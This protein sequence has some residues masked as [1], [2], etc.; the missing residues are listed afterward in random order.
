MFEFFL[1]EQIIDCCLES[2]DTLIARDQ[3]GESSAAHHIHELRFAHGATLVWNV[4]GHG[5]LLGSF[6]ERN[7]AFPN[8]WV[9]DNRSLELSI[10]AHLHLS[11]MSQ[12]QAV[13]A[14]HE[15]DLDVVPRGQSPAAFDDSATRALVNKKD[16][17]THRTTT[18]SR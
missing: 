13:A 1:T 15:I 7:H 14:R 12:M 4:E 5:P 17:F 16:N 6:G 3:C 10:F 11:R 9:Q 2:I 18:A 8:F